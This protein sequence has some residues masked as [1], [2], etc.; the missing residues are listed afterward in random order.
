MEDN[1]ARPTAGEIIKDFCSWY[2]P[3]ELQ[4]ELLDLLLAAVNSEEADNWDCT[5]R[6]RF[7][8]LYRQLVKLVTALY[9][10]KTPESGESAMIKRIH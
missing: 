4:E 5:V 10:D 1:K 8:F 7:I 9:K 3:E 6:G 2:T